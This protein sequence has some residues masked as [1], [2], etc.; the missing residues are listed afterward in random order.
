MSTTR[1]KE[2]K[3]DENGGI[4]MLKLDVRLT[5]TEEAL[6]TSSSSKELH[7]EYIASKAPDA[8]STEEE[9]AALGVDAVDEKGRTVFPRMAVGDDDDVPFVYD[10]QLKGFFKD[11]AKMMK[12]VSGSE[13]SKV[14]AYKQAID[15]LIFIDQRKIPWMAEDG[16]PAHVG[17]TCERPLRASTPMG[18]RVAISSSETVPAGSHLDFGIILLDKT[19]LPMVKECLTYGRLRGLCQWRNS[20]KGTFTWE[21]T[22]HVKGYGA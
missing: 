20:G 2:S 22:D 7:K 5:L 17:P 6:G 8:K 4:G 15:G 12:K 13:C 11:A 19:L 16:T 9:V 21:A 10:Y 1:I 14:R 18:E 3:S